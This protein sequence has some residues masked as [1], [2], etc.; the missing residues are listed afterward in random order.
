MF[1]VIYKVFVEYSSYSM[2]HTIY[3]TYT[4]DERSRH[5]WRYL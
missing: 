5:S 2:F 4:M 3:M 1:C